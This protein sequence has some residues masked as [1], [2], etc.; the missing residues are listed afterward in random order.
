MRVNKSFPD[1]FLLATRDTPPAPR[2]QPSTASASHHIRESADQ[3]AFLPHL[4]PQD[5]AAQTQ[6]KI[7]QSRNRADSQTP[8]GCCRAGGAATSSARQRIRPTRA[9]TSPRQIPALRQRQQEYEIALFARVSKPRP[10]VA[11]CWITR[12]A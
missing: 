2:P 1:P 7:R 3:P 11:K 10:V 5:L 9:A 4:P 12:S 8:L 6:S